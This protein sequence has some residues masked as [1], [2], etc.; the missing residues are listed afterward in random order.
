MFLKGIKGT[1]SVVVDKSSLSSSGLAKISFDLQ[2]LLTSFTSKVSTER[3]NLPRVCY[4]IHTIDG[5]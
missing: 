4:T 2:T 1:H 5:V 3:K